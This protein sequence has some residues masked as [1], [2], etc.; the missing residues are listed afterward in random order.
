MKSLS[1]SAPVCACG[2]PELEILEINHINGGGS[3]RNESGVRL[4]RMVLKLGLDA[5]QFFNVRVKQ[6]FGLHGHQVQWSPTSDKPV[7]DKPVSDKPVSDKP[8]WMNA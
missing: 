8:V 4:W 1:G 7:S 5:R 6:R 3:Q 2:C